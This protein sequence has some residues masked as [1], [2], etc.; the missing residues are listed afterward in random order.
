MSTPA[1]PERL[2]AAL[3]E[4]KRLLDAAIECMSEGLL[5]LDRDY[6]FA[7]INPA[8]RQLLG[9]DDLADLAAKLR[10]GELD[11][12]MHPVF[13]LEAHDERAK[14]VRCW[15][16]R[17]CGQENCPAYGSG[18]FPCWL[19]D[20]TLCE[21]GAPESFPDKLEACR[22]CS[23]YQANARAIRPE[24]VHGRREVA[25]T[26]PARRVFV[27]LSAPVVDPGGEFLG[28]VK[29]LHDVTAERQMER[30][31]AE[32][33]SFVTHELRTP[34]NS[35]SGFLSLVLG[36][37]AGEL[38]DE[39]R[40]P[41]ESARAQVA[42]MEKLVDSLLD[43]AAVEAGRLRL[44]FARFDVMP[45]VLECVEM[46]KP[47][48]AANSVAVNV[49]PPPEPL[50]V[51]AD[52]DRILQVLVNL[53]ANAIKYTGEGGTVEVAVT[54]E[55][56]G[57][58][59]AVSDTG[60]GIPADDLPHLFE[61]FY[62]TSTATARAKG[63]GLGLAL[64]K[65]IVEAHGGRIGVESTPGEGSRFFFTLPRNPRRGASKP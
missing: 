2:L 56:D 58:T 62:R 30:K 10:R 24:Q 14:P 45:L 31:R 48:A 15:L 8:A 47:Q 59:F 3:A 16:T 22:Q 34:L 7:T 21:G 9:V 55:P 46:L 27:C 1:E 28:V 4:E 43:M 61:R 57:V 26:R 41:L 63:S 65:G 52:R 29:L 20:G 13:W 36:G 50:V 11:A 37:F 12:G 54:P 6:R 35:I 19:Y 40:A 44:E 5:I 51:T 39:Q 49:T 60:C 18:L 32:F 38:S 25:I 23:V 64:C 42:R 53:T 33:A 17:E